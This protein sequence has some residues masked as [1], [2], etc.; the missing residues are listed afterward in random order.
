VPFEPTSPADLLASALERESRVTARVR[1]LERVVEVQTFLAQASESLA[2]S[3]DDRTTVS[4][5]SN[6][7]VPRLA[8]WCIIDTATRDGAPSRS[9]VTSA[10]GEDTDLT[11]WLEATPPPPGSIGLDSREFFASDLASQGGLPADLVPVVEA[12]EARAGVVVYALGASD[13]VTRIA[14]FTARS[15]RRLGFDDFSLA[16]ELARR[17]SHALERALLYSEVRR[18]SE[19]KDTFLASVS[20]ELRGPLAAISMWTHA[21]ALKS[22]DEPTRVRAVQAIEES[23]RMQGR[24]IEDMIDLTRLVAGKLPLDV[25]PLRVGRVVRSALDGAL[26]VASA[27]GVALLY[28]GEEDA[29]LDGDEQRLLR[30]FGNLIANAIEF[31]AEGGKVEVS[32][33]PVPTG[34]RITVRDDG[35]GISGSFLPEVFQPFRE[36]EDPTLTI[37]RGGLGLGLAVAR[38]IAEL[39][40][41]TIR[42]ESA[43]RGEGGATFSVELPLKLGPTVL[44][45]DR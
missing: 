40:G 6:L 24:L 10:P 35:E 33:S 26:P 30:L 38:R 43:G 8:D 41:G 19:A 37:S 20:H 23:V 2:L 27:K 32:V 36:E 21:L 44:G 17:T 12:M 42:A 22:G 4:V 31:T 14:L 16:E 1:E 7:V 45:S 5:L 11:A 3:L 25:A 9:A 29:T 15:G 13:R 18:S 28:L 39:H 34:V